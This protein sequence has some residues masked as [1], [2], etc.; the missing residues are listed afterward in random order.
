ME[1]QK[2]INDQIKEEVIEAE[3][4]V[5]SEKLE[6]NEHKALAVIGYIVP[7]LFFIPLMTEAKKNSF[8]MF[9]ANQHLVLLISW[10]AI[11]VVGIIPLLGWL[12]VF[13]GG[14]LLVALSVVGIINAAGSKMKALPIIGEII[15]LK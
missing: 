12:I 2:N 10:F 9:H 4:V 14:I 6:I 15:V 3:K 8:A 1:E 13:V 5:G 7:V 11:S